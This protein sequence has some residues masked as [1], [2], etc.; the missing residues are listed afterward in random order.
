MTVTF[1]LDPRTMPNGV[2]LVLG[3]RYDRELEENS[4]GRAN[5][6]VYTYAALKTGG[7]WYFTGSGKVPTAAGWGAVERWLDKDGRKLEFV[8]ILMEARLIWS[9]PVDADLTLT[10]ADEDGL[11]QLGDGWVGGESFHPW[12]EGANQ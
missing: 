2:V 12:P 6:L 9:K 10:V 7:L 8:K 1:T 5:P 3:I 11:H 4:R